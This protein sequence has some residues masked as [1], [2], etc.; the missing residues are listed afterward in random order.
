MRFPGIRKSPDIALQDRVHLVFVFAI[1]SPPH[2]PARRQGSADSDRA[3]ERLLARRRLAP[4][5]RAV[6]LG[7]QSATSLRG[8]PTVKA[9][10]A[11]CG[12]LRVL[13]GDRSSARFGARRRSSP[14]WDQHRRHARTIA[15]I[16][17]LA[18]RLQA[19][20]A[21]LWRFAGHSLRFARHPLCRVCT[22]ISARPDAPLLRAAPGRGMVLLV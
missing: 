3:L 2:R 21:R 5:R 12:A 10:A 4:R 20:D 1:R 9:I 6:A 8:G 13:L 15:S 19:R 16:R 17:A 14:P 7:R 18:R 11:R 22:P